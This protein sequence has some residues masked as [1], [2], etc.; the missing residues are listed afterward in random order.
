MFLDAERK[1][2]VAHENT[3]NANGLALTREGDLLEV[4]GVGKRVN[5]RSQGRHGH[6]AD[7]S[8]DGKPFMAPNDLFAD[9]KGGIYF[10]DPGRD[11][12]CPAARRSCITFRRRQGAHRHRRPARAA[13]RADPHGRRQDPAGQRFAERDVLRLRR[14]A[15]GKVKNK[16]PFAKLRDIPAGKESGADGMAIDREGRVYVT[17]VAGVQIFD[18]TGQY[19]G[20]VQAPRQTSNVAFAG[21][22]KRTLYITAREGLYRLKVARAGRIGK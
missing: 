18:A 22:D 8:F 20:S 2:L 3:N 16:R 15:D 10:T 17:S 5:K 12:S 1:D 7:D 14:R 13:Q 4:Q 11:R 21:P 9:A 6:D 19:L